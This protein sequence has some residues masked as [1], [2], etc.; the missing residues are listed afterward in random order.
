MTKI[1]PRTI[2]LCFGFFCA[3]IIGAV[4]VEKI[5]LPVSIYAILVVGF[6][7]ASLGSVAYDLASS[8]EDCYQVRY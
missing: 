7:I 1:T 5:H 4:L 6:E 3:W 8:T 2:L